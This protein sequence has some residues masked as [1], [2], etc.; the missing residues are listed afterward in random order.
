MK[1]TL[2][3]LF[4]FI[5]F[6]GT[7]ACSPSTFTPAE[8]STL[9]AVSTNTLLPNHTLVPSETP[10][11][12]TSTPENPA[13][14]WASE[15]P[16]RAEFLANGGVVDLEQGL[17]W[18]EQDGLVHY[19]KNA[20]T[21]EWAEIPNGMIVIQP[22]KGYENEPPLEIPYYHDLRA[23]LTGASSALPWDDPRA[24]AQN[25]TDP[26]EGKKMYLTYLIQLSGGDEEAV[27][28]KWLDSQNEWGTEGM[29][30]AH[31]ESDPRKWAGIFF[32]LWDVP[33]SGDLSVLYFISRGI[34]GR[35]HGEYVFFHGMSKANADELKRVDLCVSDNYAAANL[36][37][38]C[39]SELLVP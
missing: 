16:G 12:A 24:Y 6:Y 17:A 22:A 4:A 21:G 1:R 5:L 30:K 35:F 28:Q 20:T 23:A 38:I 11:F 9:P 26:A 37:E 32:S 36:A 10:I 8:T 29:L 3:S 13:E 33:G 2:I 31:Q 25:S 7:T 15:A 19:A 14:A 39:N 34:D 27:T 18:S